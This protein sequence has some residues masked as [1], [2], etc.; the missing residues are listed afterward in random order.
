MCLGAEFA[1][2]KR[3]L[4]KV[5]S[6]KVGIEQRPEG[7]EGELLRNIREIITDWEN[8]AGAHLLWGLMPL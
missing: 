5:F 2:L 8:Q 7:S 6:E 1:I 4:R 3:M